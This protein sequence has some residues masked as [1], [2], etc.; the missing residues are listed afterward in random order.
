MLVNRLRNISL[1]EGGTESEPGDC[2]DNGFEDDPSRDD[3]ACICVCLDFDS[4]ARD[5]LFDDLFL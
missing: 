5:V 2:V 1:T 4:D 3:E